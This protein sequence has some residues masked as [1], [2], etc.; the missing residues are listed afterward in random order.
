[1]GIIPQVQVTPGLP[2]RTGAARRRVRVREILHTLPPEAQAAIL[3]SLEQEGV[4]AA[5]LMTRR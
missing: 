5:R 2:L 4:S 3:R 1:M